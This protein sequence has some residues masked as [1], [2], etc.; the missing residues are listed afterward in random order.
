MKKILTTCYV[1]LV[2]FCFQLFA[3][4]PTNVLVQISKAE[5]ELRFDKTL[6][7]LMTD[8][9]A[10]IRARAALASGRIGRETAIPTLAKLL[11]S[12]SDVS[13]RAM[14]VFALGEIESIKSADAILKVLQD[15]KNADAV[16]A[17]AVEAAGK[18]AAAN[19]KDEKAKKLGEAILDT[20][21]FEDERGT[22]QNRTIVLLGITA[23]LRAKPEGGDSVAGRFLTNADARIRADAANT[24][25]R[26]RSKTA[27]EKLRAMLLSDSD[28]IAQSKRSAHARRG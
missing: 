28:V 22:R 4:I 6:E 10:K 18:I 3:Q 25:S 19:A 11:E 13:V 23:V 20:L 14:A 8:R 16:R 7:N 27:N 15:T 24:L 9:S 1:V 5:D 17:R 21:Q 12:D 26:L 2:C